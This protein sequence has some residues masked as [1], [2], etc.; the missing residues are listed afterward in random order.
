MSDR[1]VAALF[2]H[3]GIPC[4]SAHDAARNPHRAKTARQPGAVRAILLNP[5]YT[6]H[7]VWN[8]Q[9][10]EE[11]LIGIDDITLGHRTHMTHNP[12]EEWIHS[13]EPANDAL[14]TKKLFEAVQA[15]RRKRARTQ[16]RQERPPR[17]ARRSRNVTGGSPATRLPSTPE[18]TPP[19][20]PS[21][22]TTHN[23]IR[24]RR[25]RSPTHCRPPER[26]NRPS[27][28]TRSGRSLR[29]SE[30]SH[31][32]SRQPPLKKG[33]L[34]EALGITISYDNATRAATVRSRPSI[35]YPYSECPR[36]DLNPHAR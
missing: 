3:Q 21:G 32:A 29:D 27:P 1:A 16:Q 31:N 2:N 28:T 7:E 17:P 9:R 25:R 10:K 26:R 34:Y 33:P 8:K 4:P 36:G 18:L 23:G 5:R 13:I 6:G 22:S 19:S 12:A 30:T 20:S 11:R 35:P 24:T 14:V 15:T